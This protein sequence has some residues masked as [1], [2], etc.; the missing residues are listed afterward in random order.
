MAYISLGH[1]DID[2]VFFRPQ[3]VTVLL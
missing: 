1:R 2:D 3:C